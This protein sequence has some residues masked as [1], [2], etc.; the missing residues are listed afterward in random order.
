VGLAVVPRDG[1]ALDRGA[2]RRFLASRLSR[3]KLPAAIVI[4]DEIPTSR[5]G[6]IVRRTLH[7]ELRL[8]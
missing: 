7:A 3:R 4:C 5:R 8:A 6:K 2:V 1:A